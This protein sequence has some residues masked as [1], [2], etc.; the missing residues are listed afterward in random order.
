MKGWRQLPFAW[1]AR[2]LAWPGALTFLSVLA[3][4]LGAQPHQPEPQPRLTAAPVA[5]ALPEW[6]PLPQPNAPVPLLTGTAAEPF[7]LPSL[8]GEFLAL[9]G[10]W[11]FVA[12]PLELSW[13]GRWQTDGG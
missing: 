10:V 12:P 11:D 3:V 7:R 4:L 2:L 1:R 13:W 8:P 5:P 9:A 6:R